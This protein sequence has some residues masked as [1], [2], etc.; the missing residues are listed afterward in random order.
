MHKNK[1]KE[2]ELETVVNTNMDYK[3]RHN[4]IEG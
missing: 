2:G 1:I 4:Y 3:H